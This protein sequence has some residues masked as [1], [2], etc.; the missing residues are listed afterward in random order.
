M[1]GVEIAMIALAAVSAVGA[2]S[3]GEQQAKAAKANAAMAQQRGEMV[4][5]QATAQS[6]IQ[7]RNNKRAQAEAIAGYGASGLELVGSPLDVL[8]DQAQEGELSKEMILYRGRI[9]EVT[10]AN[11]A[12]MY[13]MQARNARTASY[14]QAGTTL[15]SAAYIGQQGYKPSTAATTAP[16]SGGPTWGPYGQN[17]LRPY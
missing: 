14:F 13:S 10:S 8:A 17:G 5:Q 3:A 1:T 9:G 7:A 16:V 6:E 4:M 15:L 11:E 12:S 2:L